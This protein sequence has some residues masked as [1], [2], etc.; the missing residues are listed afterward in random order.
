MPNGL[1]Y[2][3]IDGWESNPLRFNGKQN[4]FGTFLAGVPQKW[5]RGTAPRMILDTRGPETR[6]DLGRIL[7]LERRKGAG[8]I[9][10][11]TPKDSQRQPGGPP[12]SLLVGTHPLPV[13][14]P[15]PPQ[16]RTPTCRTPSTRGM[17]VNGRAGMQNWQ[18]WVGRTELGVRPEQD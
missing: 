8:R 18:I 16:V 11:R 6:E 5:L 10:A 9:A 15:Y 2:P 12:P 13:Y 4:R 17:D 14:P 7:W 1:I 3:L